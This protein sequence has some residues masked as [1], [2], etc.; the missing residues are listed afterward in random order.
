MPTFDLILFDLDGTLVDTASEIGAAVNDALGDVGQPAVTLAQVRDWIGF[1]TRE[2]LARALAVSAGRDLAA[3]RA[4]APLQALVA[5][6]DR[7]YPRH[8]GRASQTYPRVRETLQAL[9]AQGVKRV[10]LTNKEARYVQVLLDA[11]QLG[12][13]FDLV[14]SG[15]SL[16]T[17][18]PD[19]AGLLHCLA[20][21]GVPPQRALLVGDSSI[22]VATARNAGV[23]VWVLPGGYN[24]GQPIE[25]CAPDRII[26]DFSVLLD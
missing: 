13:L 17:K 19:P 14:I 24:M 9:R 5:A 15:D 2:L 12:A 25:A 11:H 16:P 4:S 8:C 18:K 21:F 23:L 22:D 1:G 7:V 10:V 20:R 6:Y 3:V 26:P